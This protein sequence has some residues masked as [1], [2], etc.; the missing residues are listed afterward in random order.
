MEDSWENYMDEESRRLLKRYEEELDNG[1]LGFF[2][3]DEYVILADCLTLRSQLTEAVQLIRLARK[4]YPE[5][6]E[7]KVKQAELCVESGFY[8]QAIALLHE[9]EIVE[10]YLFELYLVKGHALKLMSKYD[11]AEAAFREAERRGAEEI[12][13]D[14]GL[15]EVKVA[16]GEKES[17]WPYIEKMIGYPEDNVE[18]CNRFIDLVVKA[19]LLP[20]AIERAQQLAKE[21]PYQ[22][23]Y[24]KL[25][26][27]LAESNG[28]YGRALDAYE[29]V[30]AIQPEDKEAL[31]G[32]YRTVAYSEDSRSLLPFYHQMEKELENIEDQIPL[33][34]RIAQE[35]E[36]EE[37]WEQAMVYYRRVLDYPES[38]AY[39]LFRMGVIFNYRLDFPSALACFFQVLNEPDLLKHDTENL[40]RVYRG[41][42]RTYYYMGNATDN[43]RYNRIAVD[44]EPDYRYS[45][46]AYVLDACDLGEIPTVLAY[47]EQML[48]SK[49]CGWLYFCKA[50]LYYYGGRKEDSYAWFAKAFASDPIVREDAD[51][52]IPDIYEED[53][54]V[55]ELRNEYSPVY[56][57][58]EEPLDG[59][60]Y[61]YYGPDEAY[62]QR[63][64]LIAPDDDPAADSSED[65]HV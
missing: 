30:L 51:V 6:S 28:S 36:I 11:E 9:V 39:A 59:E 14:M 48:D 41:I 55:L 8:S 35:Y 52:R 27:E 63:M 53:D 22:I 40:S 17:A 37:D 47:I 57:E 49:P 20:Q 7:L 15:A 13:V 19:G 54:R 24:W 16:R 42:A 1:G 64:G 33:W 10:P 34:C 31:L 58:N 29:F 62:L 12:D 2:D 38:R 61:I 21:H 43:L 4:Q 26:A 25:L 44:L 45:A 65:S 23:L 5:A 60:P 3:V 32:K 56:A 18:T 50:C 46:Y